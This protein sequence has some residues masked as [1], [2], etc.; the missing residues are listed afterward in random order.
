[1]PNYLDDVLNSVC[2][3]VDPKSSERETTKQKILFIDDPWIVT[4]LAIFLKQKGVM[5]Q[6]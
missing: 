3:K 2:G 1:M 4:S 6:R 5:I